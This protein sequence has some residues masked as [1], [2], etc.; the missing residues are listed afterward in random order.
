MEAMFEVKN[1]SVGFIKNNKT[2]KA[3]NEVSFNIEK[4]EILGVVGESG[5]GKSIMCLSAMRLLPASAV[6]VSGEILLNGTDIAKL[7]EDEMSSVRGKDIS[8]IF[9]E[10][11]TALNPLLTIGRQIEEALITH[12]KVTKE[13]AYKI[14]IDI[15]K[16]V[17]LTSVE[18]LYKQYPHQLSGGM[19]QRA[20][21]AMALINKPKLLIAD[22]PTTALDVTIQ[23][24]IL[25]LIKKLN[26]ETNTTVLFISHNLGVIREL[27]SRVIVMYSGYEVE[28]GKADDIFSKPVHP[29]TKALIKSFNSI[30]TKVEELSVIK[31]MLPNLY[32]RC[33]S[34]CSFAERCSEAEESCFT[35]NPDIKAFNGRKVRCFKVRREG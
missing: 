2:Y 7:S 10:P 25:E 35:S 14:T 15:M 24:Q 23:A 20:I 31:G 16:R 13:Q 18:K 17:G 6:M 5:C 33:Y 32:S 11:M 34:G 28:E 21:I 4:G 30:N 22:E 1:L 26:R 8:M 3:L 29:Y 12:E 27:C 19:R 9:Q